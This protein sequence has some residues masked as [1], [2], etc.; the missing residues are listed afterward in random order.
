MSTKA[1][2]FSLVTELFSCF[3]SVPYTIALYNFNYIL[4]FFLVNM[5]K[6]IR[7]K[8]LFTTKKFVEPS[9]SCTVQRIF[10]KHHIRLL[11]IHARDDGF[12][13]AKNH[14]LTRN[15]VS[16]GK[17]FHKYIDKYFRK[18]IVHHEWGNSWT[19]SPC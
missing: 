12:G 6:K 17:K 4:T 7:K 16:W 5:K 10:Q 13:D 3:I 15:C 8:K 1:L 2:C 11:F 19:E 14:S 18:S 9:R